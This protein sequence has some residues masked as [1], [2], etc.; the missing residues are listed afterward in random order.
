MPLQHSLVSHPLHASQYCRLCEEG[1]ELEA[2]FYCKFFVHSD[3][4][5]CSTLDSTTRVCS[6]CMESRGEWKVPYQ[7]GL[8]KASTFGPRAGDGTFDKQR[9][10]ALLSLTAGLAAVS[11]DALYKERTMAAHSGVGTTD[12]LRLATLSHQFLDATC[13]LLQPLNASTIDAEKRM[14]LETIASRLESYLEVTDNTAKRPL[15]EQLEVVSNL[16]NGMVYGTSPRKPVPAKA[17]LFCR[18]LSR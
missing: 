12:A 10:L 11:G 13:Q 8:T 9:C 14:F 16:M 7:E 1:G 4:G 6:K 18:P 17:P 3:D 5:R 15:S 2:C